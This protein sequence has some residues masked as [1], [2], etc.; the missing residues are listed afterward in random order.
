MIDK[1]IFELP[2]DDIRGRVQVDPSGKTLAGR[3]GFGLEHSSQLSPGDNARPA[4]A[5]TAVA[6]TPAADPDA[7]ASWSDR[8]TITGLRLS[9][10]RYC[11]I[12]RGIGPIPVTFERLRIRFSSAFSSRVRRF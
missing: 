4:D 8:P 7:L 6:V 11:Q 10:R 2:C 5:A 12:R 9:T 3:P 1:G